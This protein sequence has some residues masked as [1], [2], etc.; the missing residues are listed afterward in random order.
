MTDGTT[1]GV[2][3]PDVDGAWVYLIQF[4]RAGRHKRNIA[5]NHGY[6][7]YLSFAM[8]AY[9]QDHGSNNSNVPSVSSPLTPSSALKKTRSPASTKYEGFDEG[10]P[11]EMSW[12]R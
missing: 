7:V 4:L 10:L 3:I 2:P 5:A 6:G 1:D 11:G 12:T 8:T 9:L